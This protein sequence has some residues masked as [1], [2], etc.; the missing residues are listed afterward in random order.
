MAEILSGRTGPSGALPLTW[1]KFNDGAGRHDGKVNDKCTYGQGR[2]KE[3]AG[4]GF[5][6]Y[7]YMDCEVEW[8]FGEGLTY[9]DFVYEVKEGGSGGLLE[10]GGA[11]LNYTVTVRNVGSRSGRGISL[12]FYQTLWR[13]GGT[14]AKSEL[15]GFKKTKCEVASHEA[16][17]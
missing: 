7:G 14:P 16:T 6:H 12:M 4:D 9:T 8:R 17:I 10:E 3:G 2:S 13:E 1:E 15:F 11:G 5:P